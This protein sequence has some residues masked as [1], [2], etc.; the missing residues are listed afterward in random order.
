MT[1]YYFDTSALLKRYVSEP[2]SPAVRAMFRDAGN[3]LYVSRVTR[4]ELISAAARRHRKGDLT[5]EHFRSVLAAVEV[6]FADRFLILELTEGLSEDASRLAV[7][8]GLRAYDAV[9]LAGADWFGL[10]GSDAVFVCAD[11]ALLAAAAAEGLA[12]KNPG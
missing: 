1:R 5:D 10:S 2:G 6:D 7:A 3:L 4:V 9:Q 12:V 8:H 11:A